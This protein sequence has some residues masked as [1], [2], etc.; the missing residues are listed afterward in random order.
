MSTLSSVLSHLA[1]LDWILWI[2]IIVGVFALFMAIRQ[3]W[4]PH[5]FRKKRPLDQPTTIIPE[6]GSD[7]IGYEGL[8]LKNI[9]DAGV[10]DVTIDP[11]QIGNQ[12]LE[13]GG[14]EVTY[15]EAGDTCFFRLENVPPAL[16]L[17]DWKGSSIFLGILR[18]WQ[19]SLG[20]DWRA[21]VEG[22][23]TYK[24]VRGLEHK[25]RFRIGVDVEAEMRLV[26]KV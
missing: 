3:T 26:V 1:G 15:L 19:K 20:E 22:R 14:P 18:K 5:G 17:K 4:F 2:S 8:F 11:L 25:K 21:E 7:G 9:G 13:F 23:I 16:L 10:L 24:D 12:T 6:Y